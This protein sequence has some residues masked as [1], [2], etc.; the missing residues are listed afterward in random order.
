M[1]TAEKRELRGYDSYRVSLGD[2]LRGERASLGKSLLDVQRDLR[3]KA[4]HIDAIENANPGSIPHAGYVTGYV[5]AYAR[6]LGLDEEAV[7]RRFIEESGF[8]APAVVSRVPAS[9]GATRS[10]LPR[11]D[12]D[13]VIAGSKLAAV[14]RTESFNGEI[15]AT[16]RGMGSLAVL[17]AVVG[18]LGYGGWALLQN[19]QRVEFS[20]LPEAPAAVASTPDLDQ[21]GRIARAGISTA[22]MLDA[23]GLEAV[24]AAQEVEP[25]R[26]DLRDG[27]IS[28]ID[29]RRAGVYAAIDGAG[30]P[31][32]SGDVAS[33]PAA[34]APDPVADAGGG[35]GEP[36]ETVQVAV[37]GVVLTATNDAWVRVR[38]RSGATVF[39][40]ILKNGQRWT[41]PAGASGLTLRAGNAGAVFVEIDGIRH[42]PLGR[43]GAVASNVSLEAD[44]LRQG[45]AR[46]DAVLTTS[47][48]TGPGVR[49]R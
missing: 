13:A 38:D 15:G 45:Y 12:L 28:V 21:I 48:L 2:E 39:E 42:G 34:P 30:Q 36:P 37:P 35:D 22:P 3:I 46:I 6:Y 32:V 16:L 40:A 24:Y 4:A 25:P 23:R 10:T 18:G 17:L 5:R 11:S 43:P 9:A 29:P 8:A 26:L 47:S 44:A 14:S 49:T 33:G 1:A 7:L 27:P 20:P 19:I 31:Q 41:V